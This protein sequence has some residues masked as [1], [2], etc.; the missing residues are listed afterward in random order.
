MALIAAIFNLIPYLGPLIG[1]L[2]ML[3]ITIT[4][5]LEMEFSSIILPKLI[6]ILV[7]YIF[8]QLI[9]NFVNQPIIFGTSVRSH[10]LEIF[11][12]IL[13]MGI[14]FGIGG[15]IAAVPFYT[16]IKVIAKEFLSEYKI[17][18]SLTKEI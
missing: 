1:C 11:L 4:G 8:I 16:A 17:V 3:A 12:A 9:D 7:G 15:L 18:Q 13:I 5:N 14:L 6:Y 10:P 2:L